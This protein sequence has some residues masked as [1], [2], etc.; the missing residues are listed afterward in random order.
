MLLQ[1]EDVPS[2]RFGHTLTKLN[3]EKCLMFGGVTFSNRDKLSFDCSDTFKHELASADLF[4]LN[5]TKEENSKLT[6]SW[7]KTVIDDTKI[8]R[9]F[10]TA[11]YVPSL[12]KTVVF[13]GLVYENGN[14]A[15]RLSRQD[16]VS[17]KFNQNEF[18]YQF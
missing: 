3:E 15:K 18:I 11:T 6:F 13:G 9:A 12:T 5:T 1:G 17:I 16:M 10:H 4:N 8:K 14:P 7:K 2:P